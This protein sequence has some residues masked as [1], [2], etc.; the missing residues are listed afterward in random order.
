MQNARR[1]SVLRTQIMLVAVLALLVLLAPPAAAGALAPPAPPSVAAGYSDSLIVKSDG[2]LWAWGANDRGQLGLGDRLPRELPTQ[3]GTD[4]DWAQV[5][6]GEMPFVVALKSDGTL[7][8]WG[9]NQN[10]ELGLGAWSE[11]VLSPT[12]V[13]SDADWAAV[14]CGDEHTLALKQDGTL[15]AWGSNWYGQLGL[16]PNAL[17]T[18]PLSPSFSPVHVGSATWQSVACGYAHSI[19]VR[20]DGT[21]WGWG[22]NDYGQLGRGTADTATHVVPVQIGS[23]GT[24]A[25]AG[26]GFLASFGIRGD[27]S[28]YAWGWNNGGV[29]GDGSTVDRHAPVHVGSGTDWV[30]VAGA[31]NYTAGVKSDGSLWAWG[32]NSYGEVGLLT[33]GAVVDPRRVGT[34]SDWVTVEPGAYHLLALSSGGEFGSCGAGFWGQTGIGYSQYRPLGEQV[35]TQAGWHGIDAGLGHS[36]GV[37]DDG[38]L[39]TW[40]RN[41]WGEL[42]LGADVAQCQFPAAGRRRHRL[43]ERLLRRQHQQRLHRGH[44]DRRHAVGLGH[45]RRRPARPR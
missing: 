38:T 16:D 36:A 6:I 11:A 27:G 37:R 33:I 19:A 24:W 4:T 29:L 34:R 10:G 44:Q 39:W 40:G 1:R 31:N 20:S 45:Q 28:L 8:A 3:V 42:G 22:A 7:W 14:A 30:T 21:L 35:G 43:G 26:C 25:K 5:A 17:D 32:Y 23:A 12:Q 41:S 2:S 13:G 18:E 9:D 15:W